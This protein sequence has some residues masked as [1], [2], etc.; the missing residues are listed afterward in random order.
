MAIPISRILV[1][2]GSGLIGHA[3]QEIVHNEHPPMDGE[4][5]MFATSADC[6]LT[7]YEGA[8]T[9]FEKFRPTHV[10]HLAGR[11]G[12]LFCNMKYNA[13]FWKDNIAMQENVFNLCKELNVVKLVSALSTCI[14][15]DKTSYP[16]NESMIHDGPPHPS[17]MGYAYA[18]RMV[19]TA[20]R[21]CF[22]LTESA[23]HRSYRLML[24]IDCTMTNTG[25]CI[26]Q[27]C[28]A[29]CSARL[30]ILA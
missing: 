19:S 14:F 29:T 2:G 9:L 12:G 25:V 13:D 15:P 16:I 22:C 6:D 17:N 11:V 18:K 8:R 26:H 28:L 30:T 7:S 27:L 24:F 5:W 4:L 23:C 20:G 21:C 10:I 1:T 3:V